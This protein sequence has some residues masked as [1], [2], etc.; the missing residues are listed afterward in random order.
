MFDIVLDGLDA[1]GTGLPSS[2]DSALFV[3][4]A[5]RLGTL[6]RHTAVVEETGAAVL[7]AQRGGFGLV[8]GVDRLGGAAL[9]EHGAD[10]VVTDLSEVRVRGRGHAA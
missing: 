3:Q 8:V 2:P 10:L 4:A 9:G 6:P 5:L 1:P 7:A